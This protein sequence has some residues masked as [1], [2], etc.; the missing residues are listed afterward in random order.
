[1]E[2]CHITF[3]AP[4]SIFLYIHLCDYPIKPFTMLYSC[5]LIKLF[6]N[7]SYCHF[8]LAHFLFSHSITSQV[9][10]CQKEPSYIY[11]QKSVY[12]LPAMSF[13]QVYRLS[14][15][16]EQ[17][18]V[19]NFANFQINQHKTLKKAVKNTRSTKKCFSSKVRRTCLPTNVYP[20]PNSIR[21]VCNLSMIFCS[22]V[23]SE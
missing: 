11:W 15:C 8:L 20:F 6:F 18:L 13:L 9:P 22:S 23:D 14:F 2:L 19:S 7:F 1:M 17:I 16:K 5:C 12:Y 10:L 21:N 3:Y 4:S